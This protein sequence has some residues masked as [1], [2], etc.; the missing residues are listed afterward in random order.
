M[1]GHFDLSR[2]RTGGVNALVE[3]DR[4]PAQCFERHCAGD[5]SEACNSFSA[6]QRERADG[7]HRLCA[8][9]ECESFFYF[10]LKWLDFSAAQ[11]L[12]ARHFFVAIKSFAFADYG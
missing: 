6:M 5:V 8:V 12:R 9:Q 1:R 7:S 4:R 10:E 3:S 11:R 2:M